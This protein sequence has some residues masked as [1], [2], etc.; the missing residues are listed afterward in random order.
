MRSEM[1]FCEQLK[2]NRMQCEQFLLNINATCTN[3][4]VNRYFF[5]LDRWTEK[6]SKL[7]MELTARPWKEIKGP[8]QAL[9]T[10]GIKL[11][12]DIQCLLSK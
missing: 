1:D 9:I 7:L 4:W 6:N 11:A 12:T 5:L 10:R 2:A 3:L 8:S